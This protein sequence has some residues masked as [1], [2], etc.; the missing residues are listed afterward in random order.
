MMRRILGASLLLISTVVNGNSNLLERDLFRA[1]DIIR[2]LVVNVEDTE[3]D[4]TIVHLDVHYS[5][6]HKSEDLKI[7]SAKPA[8]WQ[9]GEQVV[10]FLDKKQ[11]KHK[12]RFGKL[13]KYIVRRLSEKEI[14]FNQ[15]NQEDYY[16]RL[17][18]GK[19]QELVLK[20]KQEPFQVHTAN[21]IPK[22]SSSPKRRPASVGKMSKESSPGSMTFWIALCF[23]VLG[24]L[25][26][27]RMRFKE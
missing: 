17:G 2:G 13:G 15:G 20:H 19:L 11:E 3:T 16:S 14:L 18:W 21:K 6:K 23:G 5:L 9:V 7:Y 12:L 8:D 26:T 4:S 25:Y 27:A 1:D 10:V 22:R 24:G